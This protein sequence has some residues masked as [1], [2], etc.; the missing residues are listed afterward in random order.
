MSYF[1]RGTINPTVPSLPAPT[2]P[3]EPSGTRIKGVDVYHDD[4]INSWA[5]VKSAGYQFAFIKCSQGLNADVKFEQYFKGAKAAGLIA[6]A[7]HFMSY[8][9]S[10]S[11]QAEVAVSRC[12]HAG[13][14]KDDLPLVCDWEYSD[15]HDPKESEIATVRE[16]LAKVK[17]LTGRTPIIY[18]SNYLPISL[19]NP[20]WFRAYPLWIARYGANPSS[21]NWSFWQYS[22]SAHVSGIG[23][24]ADANYFNGSLDELRHFISTH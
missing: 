13:M 8:S 16:F 9:S 17:E 10:G 18:C 21:A 7:Y 6:G 20:S 5:N 2:T 1:K 3:A 23:N 15:G 4:D 12:E 24:E 22:E 11:K 19:G 14:G